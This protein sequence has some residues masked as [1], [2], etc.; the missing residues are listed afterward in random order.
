MTATTGIILF[1]LGCLIGGG[2]IWFV[3]Q[4]EVE[5]ARAGSDQLK[6]AFGSLSKDALTENQK[7]FFALAE[8]KFAEIMKSSDTQLD[9]KKKLIDSTLEDITKNLAGLTK[10]TAELKGQM[11]ESK[12][13]IDELSD[14]TL[15]LSRILDSSQ[16]RGQ[17]G[18]R[19]VNDILNHLG[20]KRGINF[21]TQSGAKE[22]KPDFTFLLPE[23]KRLNM[24]VKFPW[25]HYA[26]LFSAEGEAEKD[27]E[28]KEFL[29]DVKG[30]VKTLTKRDYIDPADGTMDFVLMFIP[31]EGIYAFLNKPKKGEENLVEYAMKNKVLLC[32]PI[33]LFAMLA[34]VRQSVQSF[35]LESKAIEVQDLVQ[36]F[37]SQWGKF[38][39]KME[40]LGKSLG[41]VQGHYENLS[42]T[43][44]KALEKPMKEIGKLE[45]GHGDAAESLPEEEE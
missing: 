22:G 36:A 14:T 33:T 12:K 23:G 43:R 7:A 9:E 41:T 20:L 2:V 18:E 24:D 1:I 21:E 34:M 44:R 38:I 42:T 8:N 37:K 11:E 16:A 39:E 27:S 5:S 25:T 45:L 35:H 3:R 19:M 28:R 32:S 40:A 26:N 15:Q 17:W 29:K 13:G 30:H 10:S 4:K 31:N 6:E